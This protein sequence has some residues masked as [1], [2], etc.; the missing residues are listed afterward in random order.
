MQTLYI[1]VKHNCP[2]CKK[3]KNLLFVENNLYELLSD[4]EIK[5]INLEDNFHFIER[6]QIKSLPACYIVDHYTYEQIIFDKETIESF[7]NKIKEQLYL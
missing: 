3:L 1:F 4:F 2:P 6:F 5:I 7:L